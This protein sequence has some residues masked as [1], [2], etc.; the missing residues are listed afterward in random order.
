MANQVS[1]LLIRRQDLCLLVYVSSLV[2]QFLVMI[3][4]P[5]HRPPVALI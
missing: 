5:R 4:F 3:D 2:S 1:L